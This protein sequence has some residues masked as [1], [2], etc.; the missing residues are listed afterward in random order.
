MRVGR[1]SEYTPETAEAICIR[2]A[3]GES[4]RAVCADADM[5]DKTTVLRWLA[6]NE[7]FRIQY[8]RSKEESA[9]AVA[10]QYFDILDELPPAKADGSLDSA[11]VM[12]AKNRADARKWYLSKI[13]PKKYGDRIQ[14]EHS[15]S[16]NLG[17]LTEEDI[18][19]RIA[20]LISG[21]EG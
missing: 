14:T 15:G 16:V 18:D 19:K 4:L 2:L 11:A 3:S 9:E 13:M 5:P 20:S 17:G 8:A 6:R 10:E 1:P 21:S 12:W 7:D